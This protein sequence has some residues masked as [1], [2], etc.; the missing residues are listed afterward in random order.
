MAKRISAIFFLTVIFS[1]FAVLCVRFSAGGADGLTLTLRALV[2]GEVSAQL[3]EAACENMPGHS[4]LHKLAVD[5]R[6]FGGSAE[7]DGILVGD[8]MLMK[9]VQPP[10]D[11]IAT[12]NKQS[13]IDLASFQEHPTYVMLLPTACAIKQQELPEYINLFNQRSYIDSVYTEMSGSVS[14][15]DTYLKLLSGMEEYI[16]YRTT[17][18]LTAKGGY[19]V[20]EQLGMRLGISP[21]RTLDQFDIDYSDDYFYG[22]LYEQLPVDRIQ[23]DR[24]L[25]YRFS[26]YRREYQVTHYDHGEARTYYTLFP[27]FTARLSGYKGGN[28]LILGGLSPVITLKSSTSSDNSLVIFADETVLSYIPFLLVHYSDIAIIDV[29][30]ATPE[31]LAAVK[32]E[33]YNQVLIGVSVD[34]F[35]HEDMHTVLSSYLP[36]AGEATGN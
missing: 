21:L 4:M 30:H 33:N 5:A 26:K 19:L 24:V 12:K 28:D 8:T 34:T 3:E 7:I 11:E 27:E 16:Y 29:E 10:D 13:I 14:V 36:Q 6:L 25:L 1:A 32:L 22:E 31:D 17:D 20:Y 2:D 18:N 23:P 35:M 9:N 15:V